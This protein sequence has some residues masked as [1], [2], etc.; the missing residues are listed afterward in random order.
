MRLPVW[1]SLVYAQTETPLI[2]MAHLHRACSLHTLNPKPRARAF[3]L[4]GYTAY[5]QY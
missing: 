5:R 1:L 3:A 2:T 4:E